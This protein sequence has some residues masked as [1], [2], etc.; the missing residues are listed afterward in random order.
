MNA[1]PTAARRISLCIA[2]FATAQLAGCGANG[3]NHTDATSNGTPSA[4]PA[5][6]S[7]ASLPADPCNW[8][9]KEQAEALLGAAVNTASDALGSPLG[10]MT[11]GPLEC[12]YSPGALEE[13]ASPAPGSGETG[14]SVGILDSTAFAA[15]QESAQPETVSYTVNRV[16]ASTIFP[17]ASST[18]KTFYAISVARPDLGHATWTYLNVQLD[19][20][21]YFR[22]GMV[23]PFIS[24]AQREAKDQAAALDVMSNLKVHS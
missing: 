1:T 13:T 15:A 24:E 14:V 6:A 7:T 11:D 4:S 17:G 9:T 3:D 18:V 20:G 10:S 5:R 16:P 23:D 21:V 2:L 8:L 12:S 22:V 19:G